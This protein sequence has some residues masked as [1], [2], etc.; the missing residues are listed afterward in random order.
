MSVAAKRSRLSSKS[1]VAKTSSPQA[2]KDFIDAFYEHVLPEDLT[3]FTKEDQARIASS[4]WNMAIARKPG[5]PSVRVFNP[6]PEIHGWTVDHTVIEIVTDDMPFLVDSVT[7]VLQKNGITVHMVIHPVLKLR[8]GD[9]FDSLIHIQI[10]HCFDA[11]KL[12]ALENEVRATLDEVR[13]AVA[14]WPKML[15]RMREAMPEIP[16]QIAKSTSGDDPAELQAFMQWLIEDNFTFLGYREIDLEEDNDTVSAI[17]VVESSGLGVLR[18][19]GAHMFGGLR[20]TEKRHTEALAKYH[21]RNEVLSIMKTHAVSRVHRVVPMDAIFVRRFNE[22]GAVIFERLFVGLFTSKTYG[23]IPR[24]VPILRKKIENVVKR[25]SFP[26]K[27]HNGRN[28]MH[29]L[30]TYPHDELFQIP[31]DQLYSNVLGI[32]QLQERARVALFLRRDPFDRY[33]TYLIYVPRDR[34]DSA[35]RKRIQKYLEETF[36][37]TAVTWQANIDNSLLSRAFGTIRLSP[38]S[39]FPDPEK[40][41]AEVREMC[42]TW[43][44]RLRDRLVESYGEAAALA[45]LDRYGD[46][47][48]KAYQDAIDPAD[49]LEDVRNLNLMRKNPRLMVDII[50]KE[51]GRLCLKLLQP[52][53][54]LLLS[55]SLPLIE[56]MG[57]KID[58]M[59]GPYETRLKDMPPVYIHE[60]VG[61]PARPSEA[62]FEKTKPVFE[63]MLAKVW[64]GEAEND[65]FN[66]LALRA[67]L[68]WR[69]VVLLRCFA[70]YLRQLRIPYSHEMIAS[71]MLTHPNLA[72]QICALFMTR[73]NP[74]LR[75]AERDA[76]TAAIEADVTGALAQ[77]NA[78]EEDRIIRRYL[79][80]VRASLRTNFF[81]RDEAGKPK[82]YLSIKFDSRAVDF[83]PLPKP[84]F[85]IFVYSPRVEAVH[86]RGGKVARGGIRWS[87]RRDDFRNEILGLMKAQMVKNTVI[88]P[89]GSKGGFIVKHPPAEQD[90]VQ[91]EGIACYKT[92][93]QGLLDITDNAK[94]GKIV[95]PVDVVRHDPDD[96]YLVV[97]ADK[98][99]AKFSDIANGISRDYGFWLDDAFA[100]GGSAGYDHKGMGIT[101]RGA[102]EAVK[103]HFREM[104]KDI[105]SEPFT[106]IGVGDMSGDVFG[107]GMLLSPK[108]LFIGAFDHRHIFCDPTP[109]PVKSRAERQRLFDLPRSKWS[110]YNRAL[111]SKGGGVFARTEKTIKISP[112]MKKAFGIAA[113]SLSPADLIQAMLKADVELLY[114]GGIGTY[115]KSSKEQSAEVS[116]R[117]NEALR[118]D[119]SDLRAKV[120]GEGANLALTQRGRIEYASKGGRLNTDAIDNS[121]GVDTSDHEVNIKILL[122]RA[123]DRKSLT[124]PARDKLLASMTGEVGR[125]VL[126]D[127]YLQTEALTMAEVQAADVFPVHVRCMQIMEHEGL[128]NRAVEYLPDD[129]EI[130]ER[131]ELGKGLTRPEIAVVFA[132]AKLWLYQKILDS[133]IPDDP[134]LIREVESY[135]PEALRKSYAKDIAHHQLRREI[136]ATMVTNDL[137]NR[138]GVRV[139]LPMAER[140]DVEGVVR[141]YLLARE[142]LGISGIWM[143]IEALDNKIS[144]SEQ[145]SMLL[146]V[147]SALA[148]AMGRLMNNRDALTRLDASI[149]GHIK[150]I[151]KLNVWLEKNAEGRTLETDEAFKNAPKDLSAKIAR[152]QMLS[153]AIDLLGLADKN[154]TPIADLASLFFDLGN[155]LEIG[156]LTQT[157]L[158]KAQNLKQREVMGMVCERLSVHQ[159]RLTVLLAASK[160]K[161]QSQKIA[162]WA[163]KNADKLKHY[164][165]IVTRC[166]A[167]GG[168]VDIATLLLADERLSELTA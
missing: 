132:Y 89:V 152:I 156:W 100:S 44:S 109:D 9:R 14:D 98:G 34:Y 142:L 155:R 92:M 27:S 45:E 51:N 101:A 32:L 166:R 97:A 164:D 120:I 104:G 118:V 133:T 159:R 82:T 95:P 112:E 21:R 46:V 7:G 31:E 3:L 121:A 28:L 70:R 73:H 58:Y 154:K 105:Q 17:K 137:I 64:S 168:G 149:K 38:D 75:N 167:T 36:K 165:A 138:T 76:N 129:A 71:A 59:S 162:A 40:V 60:F 49:A 68:D 8:E 78:L 119:A 141:S 24:E 41:E 107:N 96:P 86:L 94:N 12:K 130:E 13:A 67:G 10:D 136:V 123:I 99:T 113:D 144:A 128:L 55:E 122:R 148:K 81:Q 135:F 126:C 15:D 23:Q 143:E 30:C 88:V 116:D 53:R 147:R 42:R 62:A 63:E 74:A 87:D 2:P 47:F 108:M 69:S 84:L 65:M 80:L 158:K 19:S 151:E 146:S 26:P 131:K 124:F 54:P 160:I 57:L 110:D 115:V 56:N 103:R 25:L 79:N 16:E 35:L 1:S 163:Q 134:A 145:I 39:P 48:P 102:W 5:K 43:L 61:V 52:E 161:G 29:I 157:A 85:E 77:V 83:M 72:R 140:D 127:N 114:F 150:G 4:I 11:A 33:V 20:D 37:G 125:M 22:K 50:E 106:C 18:D 117:A 153:G 90:K 111:I 93:M 139:M 6:S 66:G 91:A